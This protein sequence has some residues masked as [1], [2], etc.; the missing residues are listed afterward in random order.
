M[1]L[2]EAV[3]SGPVALDTSIFIYFLERD[4]RYLSSL[5]PMFETIAAGRLPA[6]TS[7]ITLLESLVVPLRAGDLALAERYESLLT[8]SRGLRMIDLDR[9]V[10]RGAAQLRAMRPSLRS[11]DALQ[12][13]AALR[14]RCSSFVTNDRGLPQ[15]AGVRIVVLDE[16]IRRS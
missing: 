3:G 6:V 13:S 7:G 14:A 1:G 9:D 8:R 16:V 12:L 5:R 11:P 10:L 15:L 4:P 2:M